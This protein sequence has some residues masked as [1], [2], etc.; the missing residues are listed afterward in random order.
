MATDPRFLADSGR[1]VFTGNELLI[2]GALETE[3][4]VNLLT[5]YPGSPVAGFFDVLGDLS[6]LLTKS[7]IRAFQAN[8][9]ALAAAAVNGSQM[10]PMRAIATF[11]S[12]GA[13]VAADAL[14]LGNL[15]GANPQGGAVIIIGDDPWCD[16]TQ[17]PADSRFL[18]EHLRMPVVE[19]GSPQQ[20]KDWI[21]LSFKMSQVAGLY[22]GYIATVAQADGGGSVICRPNQ[23]PVINTQQKIALETA[24]IDLEKVLLPPRTWK[25][26]LIFGE[27]FAETMKAARRLGV[28]RIIKH[29]EP[30]KSAPLGFIVTGM[31]GP[32]LNHLLSEL[33]MTGLFPI[34]QMGMSYPVD[35]MLV[36][37]F[38]GLCEKIVVIEERRSF[39]EK[40]IRDELFRVLGH[41]EAGALSARI[42]GKIFPGGQEGIPETRGL[43]YSV[44]A[45]KLIPLFQETREIPPQQRNGRLSAELQRLRWASTPKLEVFNQKV[46]ARTPT[47]CPGCPHRD[48]SAALLEVRRNFAD[49]EYM[50]RHYGSGPVDLVAH[51]DTGCYTMLMFAPTQQLMHNYSGMGLGGGTGSGIDPFITNKQLVFMGDGTFFHSGQLAISNSIKANQDLTYIILENKT[52]AMTGHQEH[53]GTEL[54]VLGNHSYIQDIEQIVRAMAGTSPLTVVKL[55]PAD[56]TLYKATLEKAILAKG[57]KVVIADKEC[58][59]THYRKVL[60]EERRTVREHGYLPSKTHMNI[61][62]EVCENCLEC[63][64]ATACPGLTTVDTDYGKKIDTD[65]TWCVN[66][67]ACERVRTS[68]E[69]AE[70]VKPCPSFEQVTVIRNKRRRYTLPNMDLARLPEPKK[71]HDLSVPGKSWRVHMSGVGGMG[72]GVVGAIMVRAGHKEGYHVAFQ[73]KKGLAIR[74][75]GVFAQIT[76]MNH[77]PSSTGTPATSGSIPYGKADLL[78]GIDVLEAARAIDPREQ[79]RVA[80]PQ[81]TAAVLNLH[82]QPTV[83]TL[84]GKDDFDPEALRDEIIAHCNPEESFAANW[85]EICERRLGSKQF[86]NILMLGV[87]YQLGLIPVSTHSVAWA[88]KDTIRR[89]HRKN[90]KAFNIGR[91]L[92]LEP[93]ALPRKPQP[94]TWEQLV[95]NKI[96]VFRKTRF[97]GAII[98]RRYEKL[99]GATVK[100]MRELSDQAKYDL[101]LRIYDLIQYQDF[102]F[103]RRYSELVRGVYRRDRAERGY[104]ATGA[105]ILNLA[106]VDLIKDEPYVSY[107]LTRYEKKQRDI[108]KYNIDTFNG[109]RLRYRHHTS[110][111]FNIGKRRFRFRI[112][113]SDW[114]LQIVRR[115]KVLRKLPG[116]H[117]RELGF[118]DWYTGLLDRVNLADDAGYDVALRV[119]SCP[120]E[121]SGYREVR[122]PKMERARQAA[123]AALS[124]APKSEAQAAAISASP[125][126]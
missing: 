89:D 112:T 110:P 21:D 71:L 53:A 88:I 124:S 5:G 76:F 60:K 116:W 64:K 9:E 8:N 77:S 14:A 63:T 61:T 59:I 105:V 7:G 25:R 11:K 10:A 70:S 82:K 84:L 48:S 40:N 107:L 65:L 42:F 24:R 68:N 46:V 106:K 75:G 97:F 114:Q 126:A 80:S 57:V 99:V 95:T 62:P 55:S 19:P 6:D 73:D 108:V 123:E 103:A 34:L 85:A 4:G 51:G 81:Q 32:Y 15:G 90:M 33:E 58:G 45:Q 93:H 52:T 102:G 96:R 83:Y 12:V 30:E 37:E 72:I 121:V 100:Q 98:S 50:T 28:N 47:F 3:G 2:K 118:R 38:S 1:E 39:L 44:L 120:E 23:Y 26:E 49:P 78:L 29:D 119:L 69:I 122:Y 125:A 117:E 91:K 115:L 79:F 18:C 101:A 41:D 74:N 109:D 104:A 27:R 13:H 20:F 31:A 92:A 113:T 36:K 43:N 87:A 22:M 67:G 17:V 35:A 66:D 111:E 86:V 56:R 54:D 16:S 94:E